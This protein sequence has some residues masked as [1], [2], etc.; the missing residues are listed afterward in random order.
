MKTIIMAKDIPQAKL[1]TKDKSVCD[2]CDQQIE[3]TMDPGFKDWNPIFNMNVLFTLVGIVPQKGNA[4]YSGQRMDY[5]I[6]FDDTT[7]TIDAKKP[8]Y[9]L[10]SYYNVGKEFLGVLE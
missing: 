6:K 7:A 3:C 5:I 10:C 8:Y 1:R 9:E 4:A 2:K